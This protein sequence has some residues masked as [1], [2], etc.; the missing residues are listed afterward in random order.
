MKIRRGTV[1]AIIAAAVILASGAMF[2]IFRGGGSGTYQIDGQ[3]TWSE[4][5]K[6]MPSGRFV[7]HA[8]GDPPPA[9]DP[10]TYCYVGRSEAGGK[11]CL[12]IA[13]VCSDPQI[14]RIIADVRHNLPYTDNRLMNDDSVEIFL[15][16][17]NDRDSYYQMLVNTRGCYSAAT[18]PS[19]RDYVQGI[20]KPWN[21]KPI[22]KTLVN[23]TGWSCE[24][25][26]PF[27]SMG[28]APAKG[29]SWAV[30]FCRNFRGQKPE[31]QRQ[32][33]F[34]VYGNEANY[35]NIKDF[36]IIAW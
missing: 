15:D 7:K 5:A 26:I 23:K 33:W 2:L 6:S 34:D 4:I 13:F 27:E 30:N 12:Y 9:G 31:G 29:S 36:G 11:P 21:P 22:V 25:L 32:S 28:G 10:A 14:D 24:L 3:V 16:P 18:W 20:S 8:P 35:H 19:K 17:E 1:I